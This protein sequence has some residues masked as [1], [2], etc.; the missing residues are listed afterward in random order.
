MAFSVTG[1]A[2]QLGIAIGVSAAQAIFQNLLPP[3]L[4]RHA[5]SA[6]AYAV[7]NAGATDVQALVPPSQLPG[8]LEAYNQAV[9][10]MFVSTASLHSLMAAQ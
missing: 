5:P 2:M 8:F 9:T 7:I 3:L 6:D 10:S 4:H 1:L